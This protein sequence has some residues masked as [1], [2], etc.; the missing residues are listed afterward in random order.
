MWWLERLAP[1]PSRLVCAFRRCCVC[2]V[3]QWQIACL[4]VAQKS[5]VD[6]FL[7]EDCCESKMRKDTSSPGYVADATP[8]R[9]S[10]VMWR[11]NVARVQQVGASSPEVGWIELPRA[12]NASDSAAPQ[13]GSLT[14]SRKRVKTATKMVFKRV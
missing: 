13:D 11:P 14:S 5:L 1:W 7:T 10:V 12:V 4:P 9:D 6:W 8:L 2:H 3:A